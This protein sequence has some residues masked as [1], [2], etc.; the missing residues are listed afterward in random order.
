MSSKIDFP[1]LIESMDVK[2]DKKK[3]WSHHNC[4]YTESVD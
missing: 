1:L 4:D 2:I 3:T